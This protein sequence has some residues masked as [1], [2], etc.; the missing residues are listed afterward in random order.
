MAVEFYDVKTRQKVS[1]DETN[2]KKV[3]YQPKG[4]GGARYGLRA[5]HDGRNLTKF[6]SKAD[7]DALNVPEES[8]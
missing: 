5:Q 4:S 6:I 1:V 7:Y 2:I 8:A 3:T